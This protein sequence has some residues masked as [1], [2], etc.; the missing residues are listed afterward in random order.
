MTGRNTKE[1]HEE[2]LKNGLK[3]KEKLKLRVEQLAYFENQTKVLE[4]EKRNI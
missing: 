1:F 3:L 2:Y 4:E